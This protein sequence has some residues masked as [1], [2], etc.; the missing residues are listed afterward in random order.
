MQTLGTE[1]A[2]TGGAFHDLGRLL[3]ERGDAERAAWFLAQAQRLR[4]AFLGPEH[5]HLADTRAVLA[6]ALA[7]SGA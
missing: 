3:L 7:A 1:N 2:Q 6:R 4:Q 5:P